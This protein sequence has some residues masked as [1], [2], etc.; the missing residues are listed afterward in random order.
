[1]KKTA[2]IFIGPSMPSS[3]SLPPDFDLFPPV[4][5][6]DLYKIVNRGY[7]FVAIIDGLFHGVPSIW[8]REILALIEEGVDVWGASSMG[9]LRASELRNLGMK[10]FGH[11]FTWY[12][13]SLING[14]DEVAL[15]H[16]QEYPYKAL[17]VPLV[18]IRFC[19]INCLGFSFESS[20]HKSLIEAARSIPYWKRSHPALEEHLRDK[21][22]D[23]ALVSELAM[24]LIGSRSV[25]TMDAECLLLALVDY[26]ATNSHVSKLVP[27]SAFRKSSVIDL[28]GQLSIQVRIEHGKETKGMGCE[29]SSQNVPLNIR[30]NACLHS[31]VSFWL[32]EADH[33]GIHRAI[34]E[35]I[36]TSPELTYMVD[37]SAQSS[38]VL[39][40]NEIAYF[41]HASHHFCRYF[42][43]MSSSYL[44]DEHHALANYYIRKNPNPDYICPSF[45]N[46]TNSLPSRPSLISC[47]AFEMHIVSCIFNT[48]SV[49]QSHLID[50]YVDRSGSKG[51]TSLHGMLQSYILAKE[52]GMMLLGCSQ[53]VHEAHVMKYIHF[54][55][56]STSL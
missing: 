34:S 49:D 8:H 28:Y 40:R 37:K 42:V 1:M 19:L 48:Y 54:Y 53:Q 13:D 46:F 30:K 55:F 2:A 32:E 27:D 29:Q 3:L 24:V 50:L 39:T 9:A 51:I 36:K 6:G 21:G 38:C 26:N 47:I 5:S 11:V 14:D 33:L 45:I 25:K 18:D 12:S 10:G 23:N 35:S 17:T 16:T 7:S 43:A 22:F 52:F 44:G 31:L 41:I 20:I 15:H 56:L 4:K